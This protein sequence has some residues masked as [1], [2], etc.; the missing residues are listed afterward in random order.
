MI[1][2]MVIVTVAASLGIGALVLGT[3]LLVTAFTVTAAA[4]IVSTLVSL[5]L[6]ISASSEV[7][8]AKTEG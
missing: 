5:F 3:D 6:Y 1:V 7:L 4:S 2:T 8:E